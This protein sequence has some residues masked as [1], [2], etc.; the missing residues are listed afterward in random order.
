MER[1][2]LADESRRG[3]ESTAAKPA[4]TEAAAQAGEVRAALSGVR[5]VSTE[6]AQAVLDEAIARMVSEGGPTC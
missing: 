6:D 2:F 3:Q 5:G 1:V 4:D